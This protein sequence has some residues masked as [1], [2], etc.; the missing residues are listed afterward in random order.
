MKEKSLFDFWYAVNNTEIILM[1]SHHLETFGTT[2][3]NYHLISELMDTVNQT[4]VREGRLQAHRPQII[5][6][7][8][9]SKTILE[10]FG[11]EAKN[12]VDWLKEHEKE[13]HIL[14]YGYTLKKE[15]FSENVISENIKTVTEK[16]HNEIK[17]KSDPFSA[18]LIGVDTPWDVCLVK[19][20]W[21]VIRFSAGT[22]IR[23]MQ[24]QQMFEDDGGIPRGIRKEIEE[25]FLA[26]SKDPS[27]IKH[28][29][30]KL[31]Q[32]GVFE[33]YQ[34]RFFSLVK[35]VRR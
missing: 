23:E 34:D 8:A 9:Y 6:P 27:L 18:V 5:T 11:D 21:E 30:N 19:L 31:Q 15:V 12:Y 29:G 20:F 33:Q 24:R 28:L 4:R 2:V 10:G 16:V 32:Y 14:Q 26:T 3:L 7:A 13:I 35:T 22:N 1:P 17:K 25:A